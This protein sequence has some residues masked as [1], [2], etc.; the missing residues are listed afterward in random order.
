MVMYYS[1]PGTWETEAGG[2]WSICMT[3]KTFRIA[4]AT[5]QNPLQKSNRGKTKNSGMSTKKILEK[6]WEYFPNR[7]KTKNYN[8]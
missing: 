3:Y 5:I 6:S 7:N 2:F 8:S 4:W 1:N